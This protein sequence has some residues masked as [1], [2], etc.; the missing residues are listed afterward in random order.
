MNIKELVEFLQC[1]ISNGKLEYDEKNNMLF[2][3][4]ANVFFPIIDGIPV[5]LKEEAITVK[6]QHKQQ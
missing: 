6:E 5:L 4:E 3:K 2:S 1:P